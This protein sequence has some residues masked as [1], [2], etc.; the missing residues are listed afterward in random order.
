MIAKRSSR[1]KILES[2][3]L[4]ATVRYAYSHFVHRSISQSANKEFK[5]SKPATVEGTQLK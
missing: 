4:A 2:E 5:E 3:V 1:A